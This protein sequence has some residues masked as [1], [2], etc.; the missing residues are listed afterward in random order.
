MFWN[1][2]LWWLVLWWPITSFSSSGIIWSFVFDWYSL[3]NTNIRVKAIN[4]D[5]EWNIDLNTFDAPRVDW[6]WVLWHFWR[7]KDITF[8]LSIKWSTTS[9]LNNLIDELKN[10][11][12]KT[13]WRLEI[14]VNSVVRR[15]KASIISL[16][17]N[18]QYFHTTFLSDVELT[19]K[20]I[21]PHRQKKLSKS[22]YFEKTSNSQEDI[23]NSGTRETNPVFYM[24]FKTGSVW[25]TIS[26]ITINWYAITVAWTFNV[27]D[28]LIIN[29]EDK[30]VLKNGSPVDFA[31]V[32]PILQTGSNPVFF[33]YTF[34]TLSVDV[35]CLFN[36]KFL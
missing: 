1:N 18:R 20:T 27:W 2:A 9:D 21:E 36:E 13:E 11:T 32:F 7:A 31:W 35:I 6:W 5:D 12:Q 28:S 15:C 34:T 10:K 23:Y 29:C 24:T 25:V 33:T 19:F 22:Y 30:I 8:L 16:K 14:E 26:T 3:H 17:F 4:Y